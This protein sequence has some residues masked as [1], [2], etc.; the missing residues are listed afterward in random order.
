MTRY[1]AARRTAALRPASRRTRTEP[2][3]LHRARRDGADRRG[4]RTHRPRE[5]TDNGRDRTDTRDRRTPFTRR[6]SST[7]P[8]L[9]SSGPKE[10]CSP[11]SDGSSGYPWAG[12]CSEA[13]SSS[14]ATPSTSKSPP[15]SQPQVR[16]SRSSRR[17]RSVPS[18]SARPCDVLSAPNRVRRSVTNKQGVVLAGW[19]APSCTGGRSARA[20][21]TRRA[22]SRRAR[23]T[24]LLPSTRRAA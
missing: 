4:H 2:D 7:D 21:G 16:P 22:P 9:A 20:A 19:R 6:R 24:L 3:D 17:S 12:C 11:P 8:A 23:I 13:S 14:S 10:S 5:H 15:S 1:R 18:S